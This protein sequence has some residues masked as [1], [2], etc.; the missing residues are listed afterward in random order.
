[1]GPAEAPTQDVWKRLSH[2]VGET[3]GEAEPALSAEMG[4]LFFPKPFNDEQI[5]IV[6]RLEAADG[7]VV[8]GPPG[9][10]KTH[11]ISNIICH[12][13]AT[14]RRVLVAS[15][16]EPALAV[17]RDQLPEGVRDL[18]ISITATEREGFRQLETAV[19]LL[20]SVVDSIRPGE[21]AKLIRDLENS[22]VGLRG[23]MASIDAEIERL[24]LVQLAP[25]FGEGHPVALARKVALSGQRFGWFEDRP[26]G[27]S[28]EFAPSD[29][30]IAAL[31]AARLN[32]GS[33]LEHIACV[34]P[35]VED[36]PDAEAVA[37]LHDDLIRSRRFAEGASRDPSIRLRIDSPAAAGQALRAAAALEILRRTRAL[38][39]EGVWLKT[40]ADRSIMSNGTDGLTDLVRKFLTDAQPIVRERERYLALP[41]DLPEGFVMPTADVAALVGRLAAGEQVYGYFA[42]RERALRPIVEPFGF[43]GGRQLT[44]ANGL[45]SRIIWPGAS[46]SRR[47]RCAGTLLRMKSGPRR[48]PRC[49]SLLSLSPVLT[50]FSSKPLRP[51]RCWTRCLRS[52]CRPWLTT[53]SVVRSRPAQRCR[54]NLPQCRCRSTARRLKGRGGPFEACSRCLR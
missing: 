29:N 12:Y 5:E 25:A 54:G 18:A 23:R 30:D 50:R 35:S 2:R 26:S 24:A 36:L 43:R 44:R 41:V 10:G 48:W 47:S 45:M 40:L 27:I 15:H 1:M 31:R 37:Q 38:V 14:G 49:V 11:T 9:T 33:Q 13:M 52:L 8:Q 7:I 32:L 20:Q 34:L 28:A 19:R 3:A 42:F 17:L 4:N 53:Q 22:V 39:D 6:R 21:Q 51:C 46:R 16:G